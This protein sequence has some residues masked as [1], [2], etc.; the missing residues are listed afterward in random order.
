VGLA[1]PWWAE[2]HHVGCLPQEVELGE[3]GDLGAADRA[4]EGEVE[5]VQ[6]LDLGEAGGPDPGVAAVGLPGGHLLGQ[7]LG[8]V[9]LVV[10]A[11]VAGLVG[12]GG[13][14]AAILGAFKARARKATSLERA[15]YATP[16]GEPDTRRS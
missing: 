12:Q 11:L 4:L 16:A 8:E 14:R 7:D 1:G 3:V 6:G 13:G 9:V 10:P 2:E 15:I 5:V